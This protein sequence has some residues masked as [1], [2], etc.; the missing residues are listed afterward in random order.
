M[1]DAEKMTPAELRAFAAKKEKESRKTKVVKNDYYQCISTSE[2][3]EGFYNA[4]QELGKKSYELTFNACFTKEQVDE[5]LKV[6]IEDFKNLFVFVKKGTKF[7]LDEETESWVNYET[8]WREPYNWGE[9][10]LED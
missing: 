3:F 7:Y 2:D 4:L 8:N 1:I 10:F 5:L 6:C 9:V